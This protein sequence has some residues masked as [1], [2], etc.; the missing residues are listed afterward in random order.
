M[1]RRLCACLA[2]TLALALL[3]G[4]ASPVGSFLKT[5]FPAK[6]QSVAAQQEAGR[7]AADQPSQQGTAVMTETFSEVKSFGLAF[8]QEYGLHPYDCESLN[9]RVILSFLYEPLFAVTNSFQA[10]PVLAERYAVSDDGTVTTVYLHSGVSFHDGTSFTAKDAVYSIRT[11]MGSNYYGARLRFV[12]EVTA[13]EPYVLNITTSEAYE[14]L[15]LLLDIPIIRDG[16][17]ELESPPGT[18]PY[19]LADGKLQRFSR[20]WQ[21][22]DPLVSFD[23]IALTPVVT[24]ADIRDNFEYETVNLVLSDPNSS[25]YAGF[26]SDY[27]LWDQTTTVM[28]YIGYNIGSNVFSNYG[29]RGAVTYAVDR[30]KIVSE[31]MSGFAM[32]STLPCSPNS[33]AYD[34]KLANSFAYD[35][36]SYD[37]QLES[38]AVKDM[39]NDGI[40]DVYV[41][42]LG[43]ALPVSG[44]MIVCSSSFARVQAASAI[45]TMLN[46]R[47][48]DLKLQSMEYSD[49]KKALL[50]GNF[51]LYYGEV[52]LS[53]NFDLSPFFGATGTLNYGSLADGTMMN[54]CSLA[55]V[56]SGNTY[57]LYK[58]VCERGYITPVLFKNFAVYTTR[59]AVSEPSD[60]IDWFLP[61]RTDAP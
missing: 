59:G 40:L 31:V 50:S 43:Y 44:T 37:A 54:L 28:Q 3:C 30:E 47:G 35:P 60:Y 29:L 15:P 51:D 33:R 49:Y 36:G 41:P 22:T 38:A 11:A 16:S 48:F 12:T 24:S 34:V 55:L 58:R 5:L 13:P 14:C 9:N 57:N 45:V 2:L 1:K 25:A 53:P 7:T 27:E 46:E 42:S 21:K 18:G 8:Q 39:D 20:W 10:E 6:D 52:R 23:E 61:A 32:P 17:A 56:N 19:R 4:C 26:H